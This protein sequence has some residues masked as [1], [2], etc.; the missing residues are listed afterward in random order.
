MEVQCKALADLSWQVSGFQAHAV[1]SGWIDP[2]KTMATWPPSKG[3]GFIPSFPEHQG[4]HT[5]W[6]LVKQENT[7][8]L[9]HA[10]DTSGL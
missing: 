8:A 4:K 1:L 5:H 2:K 9:V 10:D 7:K 3:P 6:M